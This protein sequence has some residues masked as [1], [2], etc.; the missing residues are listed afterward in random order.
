M[1][2][3]TLRSQTFRQTQLFASLSEEER[4]AIASLAIEKRFCPG[5]SLFREG[6]R[7]EGLYLIGSGTVKIV[8][9]ASSGREIM[10]AVESAPS[11]VAEIPLFDRGPY[12]ATVVALSDTVAYLVGPEE[13]RRFCHEYPEVPLKV[14]AVVGKRLRML[15]NLIETVTFG[16][17]RQR[18]ARQLVDFWN[19]SGVET[20]ELPVTHEELAL[21]LG[22]VREVISR[23]LSRFR[24]EGF[25]QLDRRRVTMLRPDA[26]LAEAETEY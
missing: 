24:A 22:T 19:E 7:C 15:V 6:T 26:L 17:V 18:L 10:L 25:I 21:R 9:T 11:S 23:N 4:D 13:F 8:K 3:L 12:P 5:E 16:S 20:F 14:L 2:D 1:P